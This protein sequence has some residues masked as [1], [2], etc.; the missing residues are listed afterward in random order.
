MPRAKM[1]AYAASARPLMVRAVLLAGLLLLLAPAPATV[2]N[3]PAPVRH[4]NDSAVANPT[5]SGMNLIIYYN[6]PQFDSKVGPLLD[7]LTALGINSVGVMVPIEQDAIDSS[8]VG[9]DT[10]LSLSDANLAL[11][12][13]AAKA[14][15]MSVMVRP[16]LDEHRL[17]Q[18]NPDYW[19]GV[20]Q[21]TSVPAWFDSYTSAILPLAAIAQNEGADMFSVGIE[22]TSLEWYTDNWLTLIGQVRG[23]FSGQLVYSLNWD[24]LT[25]DPPPFLNAVDLI[26]I[27]AFFPLTDVPAG[28]LDPSVPELVQAWTGWLDQ[29][30]A[31]A[32]NL[33]T[34]RGLIFTE[35]GVRAQRGAFRRPFS[36][37]NASVESGE[38]QARY[39]AAACQAVQS[40]SLD[41]VYWW[42]T[43]LEPSP[44]GTDFDPLGKP[45]QSQLQQCATR[46]A[47]P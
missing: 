10:E 36:W 1:D 40:L 30:R 33:R 19:R 23:A 27:D 43:S 20:I 25:A 41:G 31:Y 32:Q 38:G 34:P 39:Y 26:G 28:N 13:R 47:L 17:I 22:L 8:A 29:T 24:R 35:L 3:E 16:V 14:R 12:I 44:D 9:R 37:D 45:A 7:N 42:Y 2:A 11:L 5:H 21:P 15:G 6:D 18:Q 46:E 4:A